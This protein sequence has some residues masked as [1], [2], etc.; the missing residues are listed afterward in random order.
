M[1]VLFVLVVASCGTTKPS[2]TVIQ[3][4]VPAAKAKP[5]PQIDYASRGRPVAL[6]SWEKIVGFNTIW[7][8]ET[9]VLVTL[10]TT[11]WDEIDGTREGRATLVIT[12]QG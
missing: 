11:A 10:K 12:H 7:L 5:I 1:S 6:G 9:Q 3:K 4:K 2:Q 8:K